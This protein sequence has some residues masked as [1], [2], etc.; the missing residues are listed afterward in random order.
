MN[1]IVAEKLF[2]KGLEF[3]K[4]KNYSEAIVIFNKILRINP[5][6]VNSLVILSQI[7]KNKNNFGKYEKLLKK[8]IKLDKNN[9][10]SFNNLALLYKD[11]NL[12]DEAETFF[13][14][15]I[16]INK[17]YIK[18]IFNLALLN[19]EKGNLEEAENLYATALSIEKNMPSIYFNMI[20]VNKN[21]IAKIDFRH[22]KYISENK[23]FDLKERAYAFFILAIKERCD[24]KINNEIKYLDIGHKLYFNSEK[25]FLKI[26]DYWINKI[27]SIFFK[28]IK[29]IN[30]EITENNLSN[31]KPIFVIGLPRSGTTLVETLIAS[32]KN[33]IKNCGET[34]IF[35]NAIENILSN[36]NLENIKF[37]LTTFKKDIYERYYKIMHLKNNES[38][39][40]VDKTLENIFF[41][42]II[43]K[44]FPKSKII[45][46]E[47]NYFHNFVA[48]FQQC[49]AGLPWTHKKDSIVKYIKNF[50]FL[51]NN[52]KRKKDN[53]I[54]YIQLN[55]LANNPVYNSKKIL[56]FCN[57][58]WDESVL[59]FYERND[60]NIKTASNIQIRSGIS[61]YDDLKFEAYK[62]PF[63]KYLKK[64]KS[65]K[66]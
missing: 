16:E 58:D 52:L 3:F 47:R 48:I 40:F 7:Y 54:M 22:I 44:V 34:S 41:I 21:F 49:L 19:E 26:N 9:Y 65:L 23:N 4:D 45:I 36:L 53:N 63:A 11:L 50:D 29:Y 5:E 32:Q 2:H 24:R 46:C 30:V 1:K 64:I 13:K 61:E 60:L 42:D 39:T 66:N 17:K 18:A 43:K 20:R 14:R 27:P 28:K 56:K 25:I 55:E 6:N 59:R 35:P 12:P 51:L 31:L 62:K 33:N 38:I 8:I 15:S 10:Q 57:L 37:N